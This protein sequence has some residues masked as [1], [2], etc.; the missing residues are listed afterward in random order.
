MGKTHYKQQIHG[1]S[2]LS[3]PNW[4]NRYCFLP[5]N[6]PCIDCGSFRFAYAAYIKSNGVLGARYICCD[7]GHCDDVRRVE[8]IPAKRT[9]RTK[10]VMVEM[11]KRTAIQAEEENWPDK[12]YFV[13][14]YEKIKKGVW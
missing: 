14:K 4:D 7:C 2:E 6:T 5:L 12:A 9:E 1:L 13:E 11:A 8:F 3:K 10:M